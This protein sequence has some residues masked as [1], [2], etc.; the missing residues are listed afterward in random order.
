MRRIVLVSALTVIASACA[1]GTTAPSTRDTPTIP[2]SR[3]NLTIA[4]MA[5]ND[6]G[7]DA[8]GDWQYKVTA[9]LRETGGVDIMV[10]SIQI[11]ARF[12][13]K[14]LATASVIPLVSVSAN[15]S[16]DA[17]LVFA[18][19]TQVGNLSALTVGM[20]VQFIDASGNAGSVSTAFSGF[21]AWDY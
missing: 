18:A 4:S 14:T 10:T 3:G 21:G 6:A 20:T 13:S 15:S 8:L 9:Q 1:G 19:D 5:V 11:Q 2:S 16:S 7:Q 17:A 12:G